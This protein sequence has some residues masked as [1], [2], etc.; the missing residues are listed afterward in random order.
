MMTNFSEYDLTIPSLKIIAN[1]KDGIDTQ[2]LIKSLR[3]ALK[4]NGEDTLILANRSDDRFSQKVRNLKSHRT[5][6]K[7][8]LATFQD[9]KFFITNKGLT[10]LEN[11]KDELNF[12]NP[13]VILNFI[14]LK[15]FNFPFR[16]ANALTNSECKYVYDLHLL[17]HYGRNLGALLKLPNFGRTSLVS[18]EKFYLDY[19]KYISSK[20]LDIEVNKET[21]INIYKKEKKKNRTIYY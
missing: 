18:I 3:L 1:A 7:K 19:S 12:N 14:P 9:N 21:I 6:E 20:P 10:F 15:Y 2:K 16:V 4:P 17:T 5:L 13:E 8:N 11:K